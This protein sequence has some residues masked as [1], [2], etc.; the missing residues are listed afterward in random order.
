M[1]IRK[2]KVPDKIL[3]CIIGFLIYVAR[4]YKL[5]MLYLKGLYMPIDG[6]REG[7]DKDLY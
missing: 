4:T 7:R 3:E 1:L 6:L 2:D 5:M